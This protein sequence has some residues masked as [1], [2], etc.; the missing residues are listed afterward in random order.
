MIAVR[1]YGTDAFEL[2]DQLGLAL[3]EHYTDEI[4][5]LLEGVGEVYA[6]T[7]IR[8]VLDADGQLIGARMWDGGRWG[9]SVERA[10]ACD[11][12]NWESWATQILEL[13]VRDQRKDRPRGDGSLTRISGGEPL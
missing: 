5:T 7:P 12:E 6:P 10:R 8:A 3:A 13:D 1:Y 9:L 11:L 4:L 2:G